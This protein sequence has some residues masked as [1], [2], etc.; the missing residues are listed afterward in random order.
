MKK[1]K[2]ILFLACCLFSVYGYSESKET[3]LKIVNEI[4][5][6]KEITFLESLILRKDTET[7]IEKHK[8]KVALRNKRVITQN[9]INNERVL[10]AC[11][12]RISIIVDK[13][14][15]YEQKMKDKVALLEDKDKP[16]YINY[17]LVFLKEHGIAD[18]DWQLMGDIKR[19]KIAKQLTKLKLAKPEFYK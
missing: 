10:K 11:N 13:L 3:A 7:A 9:D 15:A 17:D 14:S 5:E 2:S 16:K 8:R 1:L 12:S 4:L 6:N 19:C 18:K